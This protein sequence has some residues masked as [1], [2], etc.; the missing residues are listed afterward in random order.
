MF[1]EKSPAQSLK[2]ASSPPSKQPQVLSWCDSI[3]EC[4]AGGCR[5]PPSFTTPPP[6]HPAPPSVLPWCDSQAECGVGGC[7][8]PLS[9]KK[10]PPDHP[11][12]HKILPWCDSQAQCHAGGCRCPWTDH[13]DRFISKDALMQQLQ[14]VLF[15][16]ADNQTR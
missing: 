12:P 14:A 8:C 1:D 6:H 2:E 3:A 10:P 4:E 5:C 13:D 7:R 15:P 9:F 16:A 11:P